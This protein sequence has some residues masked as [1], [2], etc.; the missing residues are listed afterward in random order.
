MPKII[1]CFIFYNELNILYYRLSLL[2]PIV[3]YF[4]LVESKKT[5]TFNNKQLFYNDFKH[6]MPYN[7]KIIHIVLHDLPYLD[8]CWANEY[9]QRNSIHSGINQLQLNDTDVILISDVDEIPNPNLLQDVLNDNL[10]ID[11]IYC[12]SQDFYY[13]DLSCKLLLNWVL[14]KILDFKT[15]TNV[16]NSQPQ[17]CRN[18]TYNK[19]LNYHGG[20]HLSY[21][22][23]INFIKNKLQNFSHQEYNTP[24]FNDPLHIQNCINNSKDLFN[25]HIDIQKVNIKDNN[26][27]PPRFFEIIDEFDN[28]FK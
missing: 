27:L 7:H 8:N 28:K 18:P 13:Y 17:N 9:F 20:W 12:L 4:V 23:N 11:D 10:I 1:D 24:V 21:F 2:G 15:Y 25:R 14:P 3:D 19:K 22:G 26:N 16:I 6:I 5:F